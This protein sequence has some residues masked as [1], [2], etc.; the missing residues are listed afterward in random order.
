MQGFLKNPLGAGLIAAAATMIAKMID[1]KFISRKSK[2]TWKQYARSCIFVGVLVAIIVYT[3][4]NNISFTGGGLP[5][6][7]QV[8]PQQVIPQVIPQVTPQMPIGL[9]RDPF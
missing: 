9:L 5:L 8:I 3:I 2:V 7:Q 4:T 1:N 6:Q